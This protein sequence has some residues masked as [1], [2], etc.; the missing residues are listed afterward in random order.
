MKK[1]DVILDASAVDFAEDLKKALG[2]EEGEQLTIMTPQFKA[3][4]PRVITYFPKAAE[5][6]AALSHYSKDTLVKLG[7][8]I[9]DADEKQTHWLFPEEWYSSIPDGYPVVD[10]NEEIEPFKAGE[11]DNDIRFGCLAYGFIQIH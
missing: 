4:T 5:E 8:G 10:I 9:W 3:T 11:T 7:L 6:F 2:L 1:F